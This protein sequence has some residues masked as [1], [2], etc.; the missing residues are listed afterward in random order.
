MK[1]QSGPSFWFLMVALCVGVG[2]IVAGS[3]SPSPQPPS[4]APT[5][6]GV[7]S[8]EMQGIVAAVKQTAAVNPAAAKVIG[9]AFRDLATVLPHAGL[10]TNGDLARIIERF[11]KIYGPTTTL[12]GGLPGFSAAANGALKQ[13]LGDDDVALNQARAVETLQAIAW[14]LGA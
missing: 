9:G 12:K 14:A 10:K 5:V 4:P 11:E 7:P 8:L 6:P 1:T 3:Q 13:S 2:L